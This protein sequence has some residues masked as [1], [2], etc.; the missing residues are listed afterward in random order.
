MLVVLKNNYYRWTD[1]ANTGNMRKSKIR[2]PY[3]MSPLPGDATADN[4]CSKFSGWNNLGMREFNRY[5]K[6][7]KMLR[8]HRLPL[9][10]ELM[11]KWIT[12]YNA[13]MQESGPAK[14]R[15]TNDYV[16]A[17]NS[18]FDEG[19]AVEEDEEVVNPF[20]GLAKS[21]NTTEEAVE[22]GNM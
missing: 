4:I 11:E 21:E 12:K 2:T 9:E 15:K 19:H 10:R 18:L 6:M 20:A 16:I 22:T 17:N 3:T 14:I 7:L 1:M 13:K 5:V 8:K